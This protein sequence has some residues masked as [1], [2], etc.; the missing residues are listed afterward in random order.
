MSSQGDKRPR[1][2]CLAALWALLGLI[3]LAV[4]AAVAVGWWL[5]SPPE[6]QSRPLE[7]EVMPGWGASR[8]AAELRELGLVRSAQAFRFYLQWNDLDRGIGEGLY[9]LDASWSAAE[10]A[11]AL[12]AGGRPRI[13]RVVVPEGFRAGDVVARLVAAGLGDE[14]DYLAL[15]ADPALLG[16]GYLD[17]AAGDAAALATLGPGDYVV[18]EGYLFPASYDVPVRSTPR[19]VLAM[20]LDRFEL[21]LTDAVARRLEELD[22]SI[23]DWVVLASVV[24]SEAGSDEEMPI[25]AGVFLNRLDLGMPL[26]SDPTVAYG[27]GKAMPELDPRA[28]DMSADHPWNTYVHPELPAGPI[29]NPGSAA[30]A[31]VLDPDR[32]AENGQQWLYF[33]HGTRDG[34]PVFRPNTSYDAHVRDIDAFLR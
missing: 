23:R 32:H 14:E 29:S 33:L 15:A 31:A 24:Q 10:T 17:E 21:E 3:V 12:V 16:R 28:G 2:G 5:L 9:D 7:F 34:Q 30:L 27:L 1:R 11:A 22:L 4:G 13:V 25:I 19:Q 20:F 8:V 26:Q 18:F 6:D